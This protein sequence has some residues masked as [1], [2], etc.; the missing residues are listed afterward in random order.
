MSTG[1]LT[2]K[3]DR[4]EVDFWLCAMFL[5]LYDRIYPETRKRDPHHAGIKKLPA[6]FINTDPARI[7]VS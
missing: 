1:G 6:A 4:A 2:G 3:R 5:S 7:I